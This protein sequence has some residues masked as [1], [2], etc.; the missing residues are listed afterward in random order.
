M[1]D[2]QRLMGCLLFADRPPQDT[3]Y[4]DLLDSP[5][6]WGEV[7]Q[8]FMR[9]ACSLMGRVRVLC[10]V[11]CVLC[12]HIYIYVYKKYIH[13]PACHAAECDTR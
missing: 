13:S 12:V 1:G 8:E 10:C 7:A 9:Q 6:R 2:I 11:L 5:T 4:G 3:P